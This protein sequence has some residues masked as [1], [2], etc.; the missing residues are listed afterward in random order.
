MAFSG[1]P[2]KPPGLFMSPER[3]DEG[4]AGSTSRR[5]LLARV[6]RALVVAA[7][8]SAVAAVEAERADA[9]HF[10]GHVYTTDSCP[11]P[12]GL[13]RVDARG[14][15][16]RAKDGRPV[17]NLGRLIDRA[18][19]PVDERGRLLTDPDGRP[20]PPAP[21]S[22]LCVDLVSERYRIP[23]RVDGAWYRCCGG[24]V[25]KLL[26]CCSYNRTRINGDAALTGYCYSGRKVFCVHYYDTRVPC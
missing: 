13:P 10:C 4:L 1:R 26:D 2:A 9:F 14:L 5:G 20:L 11:H 7:G 24:R 8:G 19:R 17:D 18:G 6:G 25:R 23:T 16:I 15:P 21:R 22:R 3:L 12:T